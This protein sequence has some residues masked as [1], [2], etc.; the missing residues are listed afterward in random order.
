MMGRWLIGGERCHGF[1]CRQA[2]LVSTVPALLGPRIA[3]VEEGGGQGHQTPDGDDEE[4]AE[5]AVG[6]A[7]VSLQGRYHQVV[8]DVGREE[9]GIDGPCMPGRKNE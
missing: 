9:E 1:H 2:R 4:E 8:D 7:Q 5:V 6:V 3:G